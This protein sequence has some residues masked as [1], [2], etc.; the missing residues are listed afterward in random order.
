[1]C[2]GH[3]D[4]TILTL[5]LGQGWSHSVAQRPPSRRLA[6]LHRDKIDYRCLDLTG[7]IVAPYELYDMEKFQNFME[8]YN[9]MELY[10]KFH[11]NELFRLYW[12]TS[13]QFHHF[14]TVVSCCY[15]LLHSCTAGKQL[16]SWWNCGLLTQYYMTPGPIVGIQYTTYYGRPKAMYCIGYV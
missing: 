12:I 15:T 13:P 14:T 5:L 7:C 10:A 11:Q 9:V 8:L 2:V 1:M 16:L 6:E 3:V 4:V